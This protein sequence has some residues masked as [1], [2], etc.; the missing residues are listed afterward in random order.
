MRIDKGKVLLGLSYAKYSLLESLVIEGYGLK[1]LSSTM[2]QSPIAS[3]ALFP[4]L[5]AVI[6]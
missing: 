6:T 1:R 4:P 3:I 2:L 5:Q